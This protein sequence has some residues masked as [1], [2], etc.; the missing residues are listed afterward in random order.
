MRI[1][2][3]PTLSPEWIL[4]LVAEMAL[5]RQDG[6]ATGV[7]M[8]GMAT[9]VREVLQADRVLIYRLSAQAEAMVV[10]ESHASMVPDLQGQRVFDP[11][12]ETVWWPHYQR[13]QTVAIADGANDGRL[14]TE[15]QAQWE[16]LRVRAAL[17]APV[18]GGEACGG[19]GWCSTASNPTLGSPPNAN[20]WSIWPYTAACCCPR[21]TTPKPSP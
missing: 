11:L 12:V 21:W 5:Q 7:I 6:R 16:V 2:T 18:L 10:V 17:A 13:R 8:Q 1:S 19:F 20:F 15:D 4:E 14:S 3:V 9:Q